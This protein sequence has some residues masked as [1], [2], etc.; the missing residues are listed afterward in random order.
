MRYCADF[1]QCQDM[2]YIIHYN[3]GNYNPLLIKVNIIY[4]WFVVNHHTFKSY[5]IKIIFMS[6][7]LNLVQSIIFL[8]SVD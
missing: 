7:Q 4:L 2:R 1:K 5:N 3:Y 6:N 8:V